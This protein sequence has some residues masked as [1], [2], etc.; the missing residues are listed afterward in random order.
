MFPCAG[1]KW[2]KHFSVTTGYLAV[3]TSLL[4]QVVTGV[5]LCDLQ[6][7]F[8]T[9]SELPRSGWDAGVNCVRCQLCVLAHLLLSPAGGHLSPLAGWKCRVCSRESA[10]FSTSVHGDSEVVFRLI[11][12]DS[13]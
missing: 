9:G 6:R 2:N 5:T 8:G 12:C 10:W 4:H 3:W 13:F 1:L 7:D 11:M